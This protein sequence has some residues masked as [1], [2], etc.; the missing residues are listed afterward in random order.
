MT[1]QEL[2]LD[3]ISFD[4]EPYGEVTIPLAGAY[5]SKNAALAITALELLREKGYKISNADII[6]GIAKVQWPGR[7]EVLGRNPVF[8]LDGA[9]NPQ[10]ME[11]TAESLQRHFGGRKIIFL[12]GVMADKDIDSMMSIIEPLAEMFFAVRPCYYRAM[13]AKTLAEKLKRTGVPV[14]AFDRLS[15]GV[16]A[17]L[18]RSGK[19][20]IVCALGSLYFSGE[21][22]E[23]YSLLC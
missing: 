14:V 5:Q 6:S 4:F 10:A 12:M 9:H 1:R 19:D 3:G 16:A 23:A 17:A 18:N 20:G 15:D 11:V 8:I 21:I 7:F 2:S 13:D 22:R